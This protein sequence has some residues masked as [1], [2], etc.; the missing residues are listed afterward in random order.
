MS[1][2]QDENEPNIGSAG[3]GTGERELLNAENS[4]QEHVSIVPLEEEIGN[5]ELT[6]EGLIE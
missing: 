4:D 1:A 5:D 2:E 6:I 3:S